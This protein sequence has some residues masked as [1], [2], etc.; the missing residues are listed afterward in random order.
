MIIREASAADVPAIV[1]LFVDDE[2]GGHGDSLAP[3]LAPVY[4]AAFARILASPND[5]LYVAERDGR[6]IG[7]FQLTLI[8]TL[9]HR[10][11]LRAVVESVHVASSERGRGV[12]AALMRRAVA[13]ARRK[14][15]GIV[16]LTSNARCKDAHRFYERLGFT[17][18][19][20]GFKLELD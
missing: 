16:Q 13:E 5:T 17:P 7:T 10:A 3:D 19:H 12:G 20:V 6:V 14:G 1:A 9:V 4:A 2:L 18:S 11:R 8:Q 15:A